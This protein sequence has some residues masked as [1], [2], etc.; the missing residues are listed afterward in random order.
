MALVDWLCVGA[1]RV[2]L[3][4]SWSGSSIGVRKPFGGGVADFSSSTIQ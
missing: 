3:D 4:V 1:N 2:P